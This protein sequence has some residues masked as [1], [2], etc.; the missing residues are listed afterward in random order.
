MA[1]GHR[2]AYRRIKK[3]R[4]SR[5]IMAAKFLKKLKMFLRIC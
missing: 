5:K 1:V 4:K 3:G 2:N